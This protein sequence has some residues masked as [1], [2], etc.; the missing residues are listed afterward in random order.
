MTGTYVSPSWPIIRRDTSKSRRS[1][2]RFTSVPEMLRSKGRVSKYL[3]WHP[4]RVVEAMIHDWRIGEICLLVSFVV[5]ERVCLTSQD[6]LH[7]PIGPRRPDLRLRAQEPHTAARGTGESLFA[8]YS[9]GCIRSPT[10]TCHSPTKLELEALALRPAIA[11]SAT[12][13]TNR[14]R[15][16]TVALLGCF[17][18]PFSSFQKAKEKRD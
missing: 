4:L 15:L 9:C 14:R 17:V 7:S 2:S 11:P 16:I 6:S 3:G 10:K 8:G 1:T 5:V 12:R 18:I 13:N